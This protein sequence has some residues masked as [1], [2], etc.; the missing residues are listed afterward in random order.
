MTPP[1]GTA[2]AVIA[3]GKGDHVG[4][5]VEQFGGK[6]CAKAPKTGDHFIENEQYAVPRADLPQSLQIA[7]GR[8][9]NAGGTGHRFD[10]DGSDRRGVVQRDQ[11]LERVG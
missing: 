4:N 8:Y 6:I 9:E 11:A 5:D 2:P 10:D 3:L 7:L 1:I